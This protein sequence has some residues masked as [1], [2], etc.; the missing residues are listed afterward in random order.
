MPF[1]VRFSTGAA[2]LS[3]FVFLLLACHAG[4]WPV[5][6]AIPLLWF[7]AGPA[8]S[9]ALPRMAVAFRMVLGVAGAL[10][11]VYALAP[12]IQADAAGYH[13]RLVADYVRLHGFSSRTGFYDVLP[14]GMEMLFVPAF[15]I[16][17]ASA[18]KLVHFAFLLMSVPLIR[19]LALEAGL[20]DLQGC[21]AASFFFLA[22][23]CGVAGTAAYTDSGLVCACCSVVWL[24][25]RWKREPSVTLLTCAA[26]NAGFCYA[27]KP[28]FG[29][30]AVCAAVFIAIHS[31]RA[32][33]VFLGIALVCVAPW[34][35]RAFVLSGSATAP[36]LSQWFPNR[37]LTADVERRLAEQYSLWRSGFS[38]LRAPLGYTLFGGNQG[39][40]GPAFLLLPLV[41]FAKRRWIPICAALLAVPFAFNTGARFLMPAMVFAALGI[42]SVLPRRA[43]LALVAIQAAAAFVRPG[44]WRLGPLPLEAALRIE[45]ER[46]YLRRSIGVFPA[47]EMI[48]ANTPP[49][50]KILA[51][52]ALA[53]A[54]IPREVLTYWHSRRAQQFADALHFAMM[55]QGTRARLVSW[56]WREDQY[57]SLRLTALSDLRVVSATLP[58]AAGE[59]GSWDMHRPGESISL[60]APPGVNGADFLI[61][62]GDQA[63]ERTEVRG[64]SGGW[65]LPQGSVER[66]AFYID[67]R[68][69]A[70][71]Y[72][73]RSGYRYIAIPVADDPFAEIGVDMVRHPDSW[74]VAIEGQAAGIYLLRIREGVL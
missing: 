66:S 18:A 56:R 67:L 68:R 26:L 44:D 32:A 36:F 31:R 73:R 63:R 37:V 22:P 11:L 1:S 43:A 19:A 54:Y 72:I 64:T 55:S 8:R 25:L 4:Y 38:W 24:L 48:E 49:T 53:E 16:G 52:S 42:A 46:Q 65:R 74:G 6:A 50:A 23:V 71:A 59:H 57:P 29:W 10:Y 47:G 39:V 34:L 58:H 14:Q 27:V 28:T 61:W 60:S 40:F 5:F 51:C 70:T 12:E 9:E 35:I 7:A 21:A 45:P 17:G 2:L 13:L 41:C 62:P 3:A 69:D 20:T 30:V 33:F 15:A